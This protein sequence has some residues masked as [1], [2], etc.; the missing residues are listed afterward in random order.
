MHSI[1]SSRLCLAVF[2][3]CFLSISAWSA[4][5]PQHPLQNNSSGVGWNHGW[6]SLID[7]TTT[8]GWKPY[9]NN[10]PIEGWKA[11]NGT[12]V[13][14]QPGAGDLI[15]VDQY[16][17]FELEFEYKIAS[18]GNSGVMFHVSQNEKYPWMSGPEI[19][20]L[21]NQ[22]GADPQLAGWL[23]GLYQP[24]KPPWVAR[25]EA[26]ANLPSPLIPDATKPAGNWNHVYLRV[27]TNQ[28]ELLLNGVCYYRFQKG[29]TEWKERVKQSKFA[30][31]DNF[32]KYSSGHI[33]LQDHG[34][35]VA[36]RNMHIRP[37]T[38]EGNL[39]ATPPA[40]LPIVGVPA[41]PQL[42]FDSKTSESFE[43]K[44]VSIRPVAMQETE[45]GHFLVALQGGRIVAFFN[46]ADTDSLS[47]VAD[48]RDRIA[49]FRKG[50]EE[51]LLGMAMHPHFSANRQLFIYY[52]AADAPRRSVISRLTFNNGISLKGTG[53]FDED[54]LL[55]IPQPFANHN[56][57]SLA[58]GPD[59]FLYIGMGDGGSQ[60]DPLGNGQNLKSLLGSILRI[61]VDCSTQNRPYSI[62]AD[63][64]FIDLH[65]ARDEIYAYGFRN[66]W[67]LS[68][69]HATGDLWGADV[70]QDRYEEI[71]RIIRGGNYG[72]S[73]KEGTQPFAGD[74]VSAA[75]ADALIGPI[76]QYDRHHGRSITGGFVYRGDELPEIDGHYLYADYVSGNIWA[77]NACNAS[78]ENP[79]MRIAGN[80][81]PVIAFS[82]DSQGR[83]YFLTEGP[84]ERA[85]YRLAPAKH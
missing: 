15:T 46:A 28:G 23:Y 26:Q 79:P 75:S 83:A 5:T 74:V 21:D 30:A 47:V 57:G 38:A 58:F 17:H 22:H 20:I 13:R 29:S 43:G 8:L 59:G 4:D 63:N 24:T 62:P 33:C 14:D 10:K 50:N 54:I 11:E 27:A 82:S 44:A 19:Q 25:A 34:D 48:L 32:A 73:L 7:G 39:T 69:D 55:E 76:W 52:T 12:L 56:G 18:G 45:D 65:D 9:R 77:L 49:D 67:Q 37:L 6:T 3:Y 51:G 80:R 60:N 85:F 40:A 81:L 16:D 31:Y 68:F 64:P 42:R 71:D 1:L 53:D 66:V 84:P 78:M 61:D 41:F 2:C 72:W 35:R 36:Y 70:G